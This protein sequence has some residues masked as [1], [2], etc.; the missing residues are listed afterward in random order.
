MKIKEVTNY[1]ES[2]APLSFQESYD[3]AGL[4][5]GNSLQEITGILITLD[6]TELVVEEAINQGYNL[7]I[8]HHPIVFICFNSFQGNYYGERT[9]I[10]AIKADVAIYASHTNL[11]SV[12]TGVNARI[13]EKIGLKNCKILAPKKN[14]SRQLVTFIPETHVEPVRQ[15][16]FEA[17]AGHI[18]NY[19]QCGYSAQGEG[20][21]RALDGAQPFVGE[22]DKQ[23]IEKEIRFE[24]VFPNYLQSRVIA[25]L[26]KK[27]PYEEVAYDV[28]QL[29]N[30][31]EKAGM[32]MLG[33]LPE[34]MDELEFLLGLKKIFR[35]KAIKHT[36]LLG[37]KIKKVALCGGAGSFLL[38]QAIAAKADIFVSGDFK[39]H[40]YFD[41]ESKI[42]IAD[43]GH[44]ESEQFTKELLYDKLTKKFPNFAV[45]L[46]EVNTNPIFY[47]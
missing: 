43:I 29:E 26:Q 34:E 20:S 1:L 17:G 28:Y 6:V 22:Q 35:T 5:T 25:A 37:R 32:G 8:A 21:F 38:K 31:Y 23:H 16:I 46:S 33:E 44:Y 9:V 13:C 42:L 45:Q 36:A 15:A 40:E 4:I 27:H 10:K 41:A 18:G 47:L 14:E 11:N 24:T 2:I 7:I 3:N 39:Y 12:D 30:K 19:D